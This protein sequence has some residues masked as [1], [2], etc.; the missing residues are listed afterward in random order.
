MAKFT[1]IHFAEILKSQPLW[2]NGSD[3]KEGLRLSF[4]GLDEALEK[5]EGMQEIE[6]M[7]K[8]NP[9]TKSPLMKIL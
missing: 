8:A 4:L 6:E 7:K 9:P 5:P 3:M 2:T 1:H